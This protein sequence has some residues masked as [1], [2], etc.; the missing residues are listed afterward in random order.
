MNPNWVLIT[1]LILRL[2]WRRFVSR[3][4]FMFLQRSLPEVSYSRIILFSASSI[5]SIGP[6][7][8][9]AREQR[10]SSDHRAPPMPPTVSTVVIANDM[11]C[12]YNLSRFL[13]SVHFPAI[14][15]PLYHSPFLPLALPPLELS[16]PPSPPSPP[17]RPRPRL[18]SLPFPTIILFSSSSCSYNSSFSSILSFCFSSLFPLFVLLLPTDPTPSFSPFPPQPPPPFSPFSSSCLILHLHQRILHMPTPLL[19]FLFLSTPSFY[20]FLHI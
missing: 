6:T 7:Y 11:T 3:S 20:H 8:W 13:L 9:P 1:I 5:R 14:F 19:L 4:C 17:P 12:D 15:F 18:F 2:L 10:S 16:Y